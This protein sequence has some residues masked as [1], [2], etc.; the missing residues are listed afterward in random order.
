MFLNEFSIEYSES[1]FLLEWSLAILKTVNQLI[2]DEEML[3]I[4]AY[5][6]M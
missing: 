5:Q 6:A 3:D 2:S 4:G 1:C